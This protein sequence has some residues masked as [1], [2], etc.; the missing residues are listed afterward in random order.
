MSAVP[1]CVALLLSGLV[2]RPA[3]G[4]RSVDAHLASRP[5]STARR[6][7]ALGAILFALGLGM[8]GCRLPRATTLPY[9][10]QRRDVTVTTI[11][12]L[13]KELQ[14]VYPF[15]AQA[16]APG[17]VLAG[18][19]VY[20]FMPSTI[21]VVEGDTIQFRFINP[22]DDLHSFVLPPDLSLALPGLQ[23]TF[24]RYVARHAG[25]FAFSCSVPAHLPMMWG[26][27][28]VLRAGAVGQVGG[29]TGDAGDRR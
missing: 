14:K 29:F 25:V 2:T 13:T 5:G 3:A 10:P 17:G 7:T 6:Y 9:R 22:E 1:G 12:I 4:L 15:L 8:T 20:G 19:E 26:Q 27:L 24:V 21:T 18:H 16:F 11:P 28:V 23:T